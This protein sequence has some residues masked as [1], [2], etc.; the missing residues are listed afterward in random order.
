MQDRSEDRRRRKV[1]WGQV[2]VELQTGV[3]V[4]VDQL[5]RVGTVPANDRQ[6]QVV[7]DRDAVALIGSRSDERR[8][9]R[10][11]PRG[12]G[13]GELVDTEPT[14]SVDVGGHELADWIE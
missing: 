8:E 3:A 4:L 7:G 10:P 14:A 11:Q 2:L 5:R 9:P 6:R 1:A 13:R 12:N